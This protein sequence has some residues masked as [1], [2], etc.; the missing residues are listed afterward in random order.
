[1]E[2]NDKHYKHL[3]AICVYFRPNSG[4]FR[5]LCIVYVWA[6]LHRVSNDSHLIPL[7][8]CPLMFPLIRIH[9]SL[10]HL[11][12]QRQ[13]RCIARSNER[14]ASSVEKRNAERS[15]AQRSAAERRVAPPSFGFAEHILL[16]WAK[17]HTCRSVVVKHAVSFRRV[18]V[19]S[20]YSAFSKQQ[21]SRESR[22]FKTMALR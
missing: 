18:N 8:V 6:T 5:N 17:Q 12:I 22:R 13:A 19:T 2:F 16:R 1:M 7:H 15:R 21:S 11:P 14:I 4:Q 9:P 10:F 20:S 3:G